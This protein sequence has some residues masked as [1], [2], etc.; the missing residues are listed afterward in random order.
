[1][2]A[3]RNAAP[4]LKARLVNR[5]A[6]SRGP[7]NLLRARRYGLDF[8]GGR[9]AAVELYYEPGDPHSHLAA[10]LLP[11]LH[12]HLR[13]AL[14]VYIVLQEES[15]I[16]PE[17]DRQRR[18]ALSDAQRIAP[19]FGLSMPS[20]RKP[21]PADQRFEACRAQSR[22]SL[23]GRL[24][25]RAQFPHGPLRHLGPRPAVDG[26]GTDAPPR[27]DATAVRIPMTPLQEST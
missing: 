18:F 11:L 9:P 15:P 27:P 17:M 25:G 23:R 2:S 26:R 1:M 22:G 8:L 3:S 14:T 20:S 10:Q 4:P 6:R 19:A 13:S 12:E 21:V 24:L 16:Y 7:L 5:L